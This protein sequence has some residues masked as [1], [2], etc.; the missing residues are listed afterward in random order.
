[1]AWLYWKVCSKWKSPRIFVNFLH[2]NFHQLWLS[3]R[4]II[5]SSKIPLIRRH[6]WSIELILA[7]PITC[8]LI[9]VYFQA[10]IARG[11]AR[12]GGRR[13]TWKNTALSLRVI[14]QVEPTLSGGSSLSRRRTMHASR[15]AVSSGGHE[16]AELPAY[17][18]VPAG[19]LSS[20]LFPAPS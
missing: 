18:S 9:T 2:L 11:T 13:A 4:R 1:M 20:R 17:S 19:W 8:S 7:S 15:R 3:R 14:G 5:L 10:F 12:I 16:E 6:S